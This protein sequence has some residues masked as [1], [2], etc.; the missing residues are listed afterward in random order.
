MGK[1]W[2][3]LSVGEEGRGELS[4]SEIGGKRQGGLSVGGM[5]KGMSGGYCSDNQ[6]VVIDFTF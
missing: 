6:A 5:G 3:Q 1:G 4:T 2:I